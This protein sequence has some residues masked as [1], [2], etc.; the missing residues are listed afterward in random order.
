MPARKRFANLRW[1]ELRRLFRMRL[2]G[3]KSEADLDAH[4]LTIAGPEFWTL[5]P[6]ELGQVVDL[7][8][9]ERVA[10]SIKTIR[11]VDKSLEEV[12]A[13][14]KAK[15]NKTYREKRC[16]AKGTTAIPSP[17]ADL[18]NVGPLSP[19]SEAVLSCLSARKW[20]TM[21]QLREEVRKSE[22]FQAIS[23][24]SMRPVLHR[25]VENLADRG[26]VQ[27]RD[28]PDSKLRPAPKEVRRT[29]DMA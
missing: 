24:S 15:R 16:A 21:T 4:I 2:G 22:A 14:A 29:P 8:H 19:R 20:K 7:M 3:E 10:C 13:L 18:F 17:T 5:G 1:P 9:D 27:I 28:Q 25:E 26:L 12:H 11:C 6:D 23:E